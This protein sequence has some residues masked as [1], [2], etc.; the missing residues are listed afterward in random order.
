MKIHHLAV[1]VRSIQRAGAF[2]RRMGMDATKPFRV[3][4]RYPGD[5]REHA[6]SGAEWEL[7][8]R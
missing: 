4:E 7:P 8:I 3:R 2:Y 6:Y 1:V 5:K